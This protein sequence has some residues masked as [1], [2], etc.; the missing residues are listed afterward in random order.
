LGT[1]QTTGTR[2]ERGHHVCTLCNE[3]HPYVQCP[4]KN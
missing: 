2:C 1:C 3:G 4:R